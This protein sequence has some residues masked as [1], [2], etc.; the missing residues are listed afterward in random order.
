MHVDVTRPQD[1]RRSAPLRKAWMAPAVID[2]PPLKDLTL[3]TAFA[4]NDDKG[5]FTIG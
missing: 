3:Q 1:E 4:L 2:L 5:G